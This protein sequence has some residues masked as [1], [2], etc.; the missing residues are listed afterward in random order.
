MSR[1]CF[2]SG[3][4]SPAAGGLSASVPNLVAALGRCGHG[5]IEVVGI[6]DPANAEAASDWGPSVH[7]HRAN[8]PRKFGFATGM[9]ATLARLDPGVVDVQGL[10]TYSSLANLTHH[11]RHGTPYLVTP[12]GM[13]D[14]W[15][16]VNSKWKKQIVRFWFEDKHLARAACLRATAEMEADHF[17]EF[18]LRNPIAIVPNGVDVPQL[19]PRPIRDD[20]RRRLLFLSRIHPKKGLHI[21]LRAWASLSASRPDWELVIAG[22]DEAGHT[23]EMQALAERLRLTGIVWMPAVEGETKEALYRSADVFVLPTHAENFGLVIAEALAQEV[24]VITTKNAPWSGLRDNQ[25]GW[26]IDLTE[27]SLRQA[28]MEATALPREELHEM[29]MRGRVW[30]E[31]DFGWDAIAQQMLQVYEWVTGRQDRPSCVHID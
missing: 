1:L 10:W 24:P 21:L 17:R 14:P 3:I 7:A 28:L 22:P 19:K 27:D 13:L 2:V 25:C 8:G 16:R 5:S 18:G 30:M 31:R 23:A 9:S 4:L 15:A 12:R 6:E 26:W 20:R 11:R 29:G